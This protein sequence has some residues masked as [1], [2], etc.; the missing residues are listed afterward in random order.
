MFWFVV[1]M[2]RGAPLIHQRSHEPRKVPNFFFKKKKATDNIALTMLRATRVPVIFPSLHLQH[3]FTVECR[4]TLIAC[5]GCESVWIHWVERS[6]A[7]YI[8]QRLAV[9]PSGFRRRSS[10]LLWNHMLVQAA[11]GSSWCITSLGLRW[12]ECVSSSWM[13]LLML[14]KRKFTD[15]GS[16]R[17]LIFHRDD[18]ESSNQIVNDLIFH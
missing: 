2:Q 16:A 8:L 9:G 4:F 13:M 3:L 15:V 12:L 14:L 11:L 1:L 7:C 18:S 5:D 17:T 10:E 6:P